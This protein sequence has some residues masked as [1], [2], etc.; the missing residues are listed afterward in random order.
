[1]EWVVVV[2]FCVKGEEVFFGGGGVGECEFWE[3]L[4]GGL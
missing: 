1:M 4:V 3:L 2:E